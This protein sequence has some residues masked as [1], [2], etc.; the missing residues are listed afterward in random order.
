MPTIFTHAIVG[1]GSASAFNVPLE[2]RKDFLLAAALA[3]VIPDADALF[4]PWISYEHPLGHRGLSHS[5]VFALLM[6]IACAIWL[7]RARRWFPIGML[8]LAAFFAALTATN[9]FFDAFTDGGLG[10]AFFAPFSNHRYF[11][12]WRPIP[13]APIGGYYLFTRWFAGVLAAEVLLLWTLAAAPV[14]WRW[15]AAGKTGKCLSLV[16]LATA[17]GAWVWRFAEKVY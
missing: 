11:F 3:P 16:L 8:G 13:V 10:I 6:G 17:V 12:P 15:R 2:D 9:G 7:R 5:L 14:C 4:M 1:L